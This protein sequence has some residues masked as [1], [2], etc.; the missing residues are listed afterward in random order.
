[1]TNPT[2][3]PG[4]LKQS[5][6]TKISFGGLIGPN[7]YVNTV[8]WDSPEWLHFERAFVSSHDTFNKEEATILRNALNM[9]LKQ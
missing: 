9:F 8:K 1:M 6:P 5:F 3:P 4:N 2:L 7:I